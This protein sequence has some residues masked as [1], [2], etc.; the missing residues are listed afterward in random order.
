[1]KHAGA[2]ALKRLEPL[3]VRLRKIPA[4]KE[5]STGVFYRSG[6]AFLH[7]H[8][9]GN[10]LYADMRVADDF[11]RFPATSAGDRAQLLMVLNNALRD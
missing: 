4:L 5:R 3:L 1:M 8:E 11:E 9:H 2:E 10:E 6:R 7:F